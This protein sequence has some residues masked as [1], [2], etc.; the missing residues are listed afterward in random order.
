MRL[1]NGYLCPL[2]LLVVGA[3]S[4]FPAVSA[5]AVTPF[6]NEV[7][8]ASANAVGAYSSLALDA[9][10][11]PR[12]SYFD[13]TTDDL[14]YARK[15]GGMWIIETADGSANIVGLYTSIALDAQGNP[16]VSYY[17]NTNRDLEY[18]RKTGGVWTIEVADGSGVSNFVGEY[19]SLA[20]DAQ[21]N[22]HASYFD[23]ASGN[24]KYARKVGGIWTTD[25]VEAGAG[26][27]LWTSLALD[28]Q[29]NPHVTYHYLIAGDLK[30]ARKS[31][32]V[33]TVETADGSANNVG[34]YTSLAL[35]AQGNPH[36]SYLDDTTDDLKYARKSGGVWTIETADGSANAVGFWTSLALD[37]QANPNVTYQDG[38]TGGLRYARK[39]GGVWAIESADGSPNSFGWTSLALD[40][41]GNPHV[42]YYDFATL[43]LKYANAGFFVIS[44]TPGVTWPVGSVQTVRWNNGTGTVTVSLSVDGGLIFTPLPRPVGGSEYTFRVPHSPT[45]FGRILIEQD[46]PSAVALSDSFFRIDGA[47][48]LQKFDAMWDEGSR[49]VGLTWA[50][51]PGPEADIRYRMERGGEGFAFVSVADGLDRGEFTDLSTT[52][53]SRYRLIAINGLGEE[54]MLGETSV[55]GALAVGRDLSVQP[56][57]A[58]G[59]AT[60]LLFRA[61]FDAASG[62]ASNS[63]VEVAMFDLSGRKVVTLDDGLRASGV[64][65]A[66][67]DGRD[68]N[69]RDVAAGVY[70]ARLSWNGAPRATERVT[71]VR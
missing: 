44:P 3:L 13:D 68:K 40:A 2:A 33:W 62:G 66:T 17:D 49:A 14:K 26:T 51:T 41:Q 46:A 34:K 56:N 42:S 38:T 45:R 22:P 43:D 15:S 6:V 1:I 20:L 36:V 55:T 25:A 47:I 24:M 27:G 70:F 63:R 67:W 69:G 5:H 48:T 19:T 18:A 64:H 23:N 11:N 61:P 30:Y 31:G 52:K 37:A 10:G 53:A 54:Y 71:I 28:A 60:T 16:H 58:R 4:A 12:V 29:G 21:G 50:T 39:S 32:G 59:G 7:G 57:P 8:D 65:T 9:Q 35:D